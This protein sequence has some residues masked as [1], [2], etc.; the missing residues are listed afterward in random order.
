MGLGG[1]R[2]RVPE[3][4]G[5][6]AELCRRPLL[7]R[8]VS[9]RVRP[10]AGG[11][12]GSAQSRGTGS[13]RA[14]AEGEHGPSLLLPGAVRRRRERVTRRWP[15][16][17][18][19]VHGPVGP[20]PCLRAE[21]DGAGGP[22]ITPEGRHA[23]EE[24]ERPG[25]AGP[26]TGG[27]RAARGGTQ[28]PHDAAGGLAERLRALV[29]LRARLYRPWREGPGVRVAGAGLPGAFNGARLPPSRSS[30]RSV[31]IGS[32]LC[33]ARAADGIPVAILS[34]TTERRSALRWGIL[35]DGFAAWIPVQAALLATGP[36][37]HDAGDRMREAR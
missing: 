26:R 7:I 11:H 4:T 12:R 9:C 24:P 32:P 35:H 15:D 28:I 36:R 18:D 30:T 31:A 14:L 13:P 19:A 27:P 22:G 21:G 23:F 8:P 34:R 33:G 20:R 16:R 1:R 25:V 2:A 3:G 29:L 17:R 10:H 5:S 6:E 37:R